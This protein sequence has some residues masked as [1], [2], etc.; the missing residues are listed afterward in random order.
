MKDLSKL[1]RIE[2]L[3]ILLFVFFKF[4]RKPIIQ[5]NYPDYLKTFLFSFPNLCEAIIGTFT[6]TA[7]GLIL[8]KKWRKPASQLKEQTIYLLAVILA[9]IYVI[10]QE[11]KLH[12][13]GGKNIY[14]PMDVLF[15]IIGLIIA[16]V[17]IIRISPKYKER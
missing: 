13:L 3:I 9:G 16:Y 7:I 4:I 15:S 5:G 17:W 12:N 8:N 11:F 1:M 2:I 10:T 14:D 6:L